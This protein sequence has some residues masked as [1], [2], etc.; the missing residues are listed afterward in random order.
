MKSNQ[1]WVLT[2][3]VYLGIL[4]SISLAAYLKVI[5]SEISKFPYYDTILHFL[6]LG[7]AAYLSHLALNKRKI[8]FLN[9]SLPLAPLIVIFFCVIDEIIQLFVPYRSFDL[10]DLA[11]DLCGIVLFTWLAE[12]QGQKAGEQESR[13]R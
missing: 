7:I 12:R 2:F 13:G 6:L 1:R 5:P 8:K 10:V 3:W 9:I 4:I 11:A